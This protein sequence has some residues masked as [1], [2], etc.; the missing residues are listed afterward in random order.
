MKYRDDAL[1]PDTAQ[2]KSEDREARLLHV[3]EGITRRRSGGDL[4]P[5]HLVLAEHPDLQ[6]E[7]GESLADLRRIEE[8]EASAVG[9]ATDDEEDQPDHDP[10]GEAASYLPQPSLPGYII[11]QEVH[12]GGQG[13]VYRAVQ[14]T[15]GRQVAIKVLHDHGLASKEGR[16]RFDQEVRILGQLRHPSIVTIHDRGTAHGKLYLVMDFISGLS[17]DEYCATRHLTIDQTLRLFIK[18]CDAVNAAHLHGVIHRDLKPNNIHVDER[19]EPYILDFGLAKL[20]PEGSGGLAPHGPMTETGQFVGSLP[21]SSPEQAQGDPR[22]MDLRTD[23]YS[24]GVNVYQMLTGRFP[25]VVEG[26][27]RDVLTNIID[28]EPKSLRALRSDIPDDIDAIVRKCLRKEPEGRYQSAAAIAEDVQRYLDKQPIMARAPS[29]LY[30]LRKLAARH[31]LPSALLATLAVVLCGTVG[32]MT[33]QRQHERA[34]VRRAQQAEQRAFTEAESAKA[35]NSFLVNDLLAGVRPEIARGDSPTLR[36]ALDTAAER[37]EQAFPHQPLVEASVRAVIGQSYASLGLY[38]EAEPHVRKALELRTAASG[39]TDRDALRSE[40]QLANLLCSQARYS[41][42]D[43]LTLRILGTTQRVFAHEDELTLQARHQR[44]MLQVFLG[45]LQE[46]EQIFEELLETRTRLEGENDRS[47]IGA[48]ADWAYITLVRRKRQ[49]EAEDTYDTI[50]QQCRELFGDDHPQTLRAMLNVAQTLTAQRKL[51]EAEEMFGRTLTG[52][53]RVLGEDHPEMVF[54]KLLFARLRQNQGRLTE[55]IGLLQDAADVGRRVLGAEHPITLQAQEALGH[56]LGLKG[57][58]ARSE[59]IHRET[60]ARHRSIYGDNHLSTAQ[61]LECLGMVLSWMGRHAEAER[62]FRESYTIF[63]SSLG[64]AEP[65]ASPIRGLVSSLAA[66]GR[67]EEARPFS[68]ELLKLREAAAEDPATDAYRLNCY[69]RALVTVYPLDLRDSGLA[70]AYALRAYG[71]STDEYHY[72]RYI[73]ALAYEAEGEIEQAMT[74]LRRALDH[75]PWEDSQERRWYETALVR[76]LEELGD[77]DDAAG[78]Y[79][80]TLAHRREELADEPLEIAESLARLG[81]TLLRQNKPIAAEAPLREC[82]ALR[83]AKLPGDHWRIGEAMSLLGAAIREQG[84]SPEAEELLTMGYD[85]LKRSPM[86]QSDAASAARVRAE[87]QAESSWP[88]RD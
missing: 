1:K 68:E 47:S 72:N 85:L 15:T 21:W 23:V 64:S 17:L 33:Y 5:D 20:A 80:T 28:V 27:A 84:T 44:A 14:E 61:S 42:A 16:I 41:E 59:A 62:C 83:E 36:D 19:G 55:A 25:Y 86:A 52:Y 45:R 40:L 43:S 49:A 65:V 8:A 51:L 69:A 56:N 31:R 54:L 66:Q 57:E 9:S 87:S 13:V 7:L 70:V 71:M 79:R 81:E 18:I 30:Q 78:V 29:T 24:L 46:A 63:E 22:H 6:P 3:L 12:R 67:G 53:R 39:P 50:L 82:L 2:M 4:L 10:D 34:L 74:M 48:R 26:G 35:V 73:L 88:Q 75:I 32:W 37:I 58:Y 38:W 76:I 77:H 60:L 11:S